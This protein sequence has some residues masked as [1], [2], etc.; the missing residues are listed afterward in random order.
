MTDIEWILSTAPIGIG[1]VQASWTS[2]GLEVVHHRP[3][4]AVDAWRVYDLRECAHGHQRS[5]GV[6]FG[7]TSLGEISERRWA[8]FRRTHRRRDQTPISALRALLETPGA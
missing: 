5:D 8:A 3:D 6:S 1:R 2:D 7:E 4:G